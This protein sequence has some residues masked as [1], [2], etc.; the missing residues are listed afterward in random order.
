MSYSLLRMRTDAFLPVGSLSI[1]NFGKSGVSSFDFARALPLRKRFSCTPPFALIAAP[2][3]ACVV[4][5]F[6]TFE[7]Y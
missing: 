4:S 2:A 7:R 5:L 1:Q 3:L 6:L